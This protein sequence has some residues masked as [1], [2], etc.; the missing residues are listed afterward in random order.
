MTDVMPEIQRSIVLKFLKSKLGDNIQVS[1]NYLQ[2]FSKS[3]TLFMLYLTTISQEISGFKHKISVDD[4]K[5][6]MQEIG[7]ENYL[8]Q[9][10]DINISDSIHPRGNKNK[11][12][13]T[14]KK[15]NNQLD[16]Q[17]E[18][19]QE[20][21]ADGVGEENMDPAENKEDYEVLSD[22]EIE[23]PEAGELSLEIENGN[24]PHAI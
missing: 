17:M 9:L 7:F 16:L 5:K 13:S 19:P 22:I 2:D 1:S 3:L 14:G 11:R 6:A 18:E 10:D 4:V 21:L 12:K 8:S 23:E 24:N 15:D 20:V